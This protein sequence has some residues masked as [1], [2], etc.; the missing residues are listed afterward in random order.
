MST[1]G[2]SAFRH[3]DFALFWVSLVTEAQWHLGPHVFVRFNQEVGLTSKATDW[4]PQLGI[5]VNLPTG[6]SRR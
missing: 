4:E 3:R 5:L 6:R 2:R 1:A